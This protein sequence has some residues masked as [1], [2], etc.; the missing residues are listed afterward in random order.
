MNAK[1]NIQF[2]EN[3]FHSAVDVLDAYSLALETTTQVQVL[4]NRV[5]KE[6]KRIK[7]IEQENS[8]T[9]HSF[10]EFENLISV[11]K[12]LAENYVNIFDL[13]YENASKNIDVRYDIADLSNAYSLACE[14]S[15]WFG[16]ILY[17]LK[18]E[19]FIIKENSKVLCDAVFAGLENLINI[20]DYLSNNHRNTF[21]I[22][23]EKY[24]AEWRV[25]K[26]D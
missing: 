11:A 9:P 24:E 13:E 8:T 4:I 2:P 6:T 3:S 26:N 5:S 14:I 25:S 19:L 16:T 12:Y 23:C 21:K 22:E 18:D 7:E 1:V 10:T 15:S 20:A 17:Q